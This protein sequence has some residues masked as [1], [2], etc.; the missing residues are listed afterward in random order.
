MPDFNIILPSKPKIVSE[1]EFSGVYEIDSLY[2]GYGHTLGNSLR[3]IILSSLPGVAITSVKIDS[4]S[5]EF[6][7]LDGVKEDV[8]TILLN[9]KKVNFKIT[10]DEP[11]EITLNISGTKKITAE[12]LKVPGQVEILNKDQFIAEITDK[13]GSL[14]ITMMIEKGLGYV[15]KEVLQ[16]DKVEI[17]TLVLD[18]VFTPI[19]RVNYEVENM[20]VGDRTDYNKLRIS[21]ETDGTLTP[22][23]ALEDSIFIMIQQ[24][25]AIVGFQEEEVSSEVEGGSDAGIGDDGVQE[26]S[27][28]G[29]DKEF[30]KTR[31]DSLG[32]STRTANALDNSNIRT[33]GGLARKSEQELLEL[34]G[35][36]EKGIQE[37]KRTLGN[38]GIV[39]K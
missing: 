11:Q 17:G 14:N 26:E 4:V 10:T 20:R 9:L 30:L 38:F 27:Q 24:L 8:I 2:P 35:L 1:K 28:A 32:F 31:V 21:I 12:D 33:I 25:K 37:I 36:G 16:K 29:E 22:R 6:S 19:R 13:K 15:P 23:K 7:T 3:R 5:H 34:E 39:L 18:A